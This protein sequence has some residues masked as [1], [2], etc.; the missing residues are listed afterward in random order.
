MK[1]SILLAAAFVSANLMGFSYGLE[2]LKVADGVHCIFGN[3]GAPNDKNN[4]NIVNS[5]YIELQDGLLAIDSGPTYKYAKE[6]AQKIEKK[7]SKKI[8]LVLNTHYHND[9]LGGNAYYKARKIEIL[10]DSGIKEAYEKIPERFDSYKRVVSKEAWE[11]SVVTL[12]TMYID[13]NLTIKGKLGDLTIFK[14]SKKAHTATDLVVYYPAA[15][16]VIAGDIAYSQMIVPLRDGSV[17]GSLDALKE[18]GKLDFSHIIGGHGKTTG[19]E[20]YDFALSYITT[21]REGVKNAMDKGVELESIT[22]S[23][24]ME[25]FKDAALWDENPKNIIIAYQEAEMEQ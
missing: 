24:N 15:K 18:I 16:T 11:K 2:P 23:V 25:R 14:P 22:K 12:P 10:G 19:R 8:T 5:C 6:A 3:P 20:S 7:L 9:H 17:K 13:S 4:G 21:L 1:K